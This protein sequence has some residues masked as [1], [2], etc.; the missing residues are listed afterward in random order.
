MNEDLPPVPE[1]TERQPVG[2]LTDFVY[3]HEEGKPVE[4]DILINE[5]GKVVLFHSHIF[6]DELGWFECDLDERRLSFVFDDGRSV[7]S[8]VQISDDMSKYMQNSH[9]LLTVLL[10]QETGEAKEGQYL[11]LILQKV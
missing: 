5:V 1:T 2:N 4:I 3:G 6:K 11:P 8:G 7:D 10:D 9:Q